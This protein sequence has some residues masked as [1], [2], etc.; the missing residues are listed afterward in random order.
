MGCVKDSTIQEVVSQIQTSTGLNTIQ[1]QQIIDKMRARATPR[2][3][4]ILDKALAETSSWQF[5]GPPSNM[6]PG[7][8]M[9]RTGS[10]GGGVVVEYQRIIDPETGEHEITTMK[11][12][13]RGSEHA[14][15]RGDDAPHAT[16]HKDGRWWDEYGN[17]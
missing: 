3:Q 14:P 6:S 15:L 16:M 8:E 2:Q 10:V 12:E 7:Q 9:F 4:K 5:G 1:K 17:D 11:T 13:T